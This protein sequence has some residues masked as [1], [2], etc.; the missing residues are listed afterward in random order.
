MAKI[1]LISCVSKKDKKNPDIPLEAKCL[2]ISNY[3]KNQWEYANLKQPDKIFILSGKYHLLEPNEKIKYYECPLRGMKKPQRQAWADE[4]IKKLKEKCDFNEDN[5]EIVAG[6]NYF[7]F[8]K[9]KL[10]N[11]TIIFS[12]KYGVKNMGDFNKKLKEQ[13]NILRAQKNE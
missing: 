3:F 4:V 10:P 11:R 8:M 2:Y 13:I 6:K 5:F 9:D 1:I 12:K 7:E